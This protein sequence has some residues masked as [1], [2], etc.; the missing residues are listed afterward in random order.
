MAQERRARFW[1]EST[2]WPPAGKY[3][4]VSKI[5]R[6][7]PPHPAVHSARGGGHYPHS[8]P[9]G[10]LSSGTG[11][12]QLR[13]HP[14]P[15]PAPR[16]GL[17]LPLGQI[18][19]LLSPLSARLL[20]LHWLSFWCEFMG[21]APFRGPVPKWPPSPG[22]QQDQPDNRGPLLHLPCSGRLTVPRAPSL[23]KRDA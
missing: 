4:W 8:P 3:V 11:P 15:N 9:G 17:Q 13:E 18:C 12:Q 2:Q 23:A 6:I 21:R 5:Q 16:V 7:K 10:P 22:D 19:L 1:E 20:P 14:R